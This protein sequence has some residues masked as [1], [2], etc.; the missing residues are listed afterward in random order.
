MSA[1][2]KQVFTPTYL[3]LR[4]EIPIATTCKI[5]AS[6]DDT[7]VFQKVK[8]ILETKLWFRKFMSDQCLYIKRD[9]FRVIVICSFKQLKNLKETLRNIL[10]KRKKA[11]L[12]NR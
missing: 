2:L 9:Q 5:W 12:Q 4:T 10:L 7:L 8:I 6:T 3:Q 1:R 11:K